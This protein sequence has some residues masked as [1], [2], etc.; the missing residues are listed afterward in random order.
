M[1]TPRRLTE[2]A[3]SLTSLSDLPRCRALLIPGVA[4]PILRLQRLPLLREFAAAVVLIACLSGGRLAVLAVVDGLLALAGALLVVLVRLAFPR[5]HRTFVVRALP[6]GGSA[7]RAHRQ[8]LLDSA[9][10]HGI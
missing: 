6:L 8:S 10:T 4:E 7:P 5:R 1:R 9:M 2:G 3:R